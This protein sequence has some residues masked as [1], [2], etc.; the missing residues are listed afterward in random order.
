MGTKQEFRDKAREFLENFRSYVFYLF[1]VD[2]AK[3]PQKRD[4][5]SINK[6]KRSSSKI[7]QE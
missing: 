6:M 3:R 4:K 5:I 1:Y 7:E 2:L